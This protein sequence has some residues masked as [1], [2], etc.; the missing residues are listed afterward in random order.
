MNEMKKPKT[1]A[2]HGRLWSA[3][4]RD[5][6]EFQEV[7]FRPAYEAVFA[8]VG[9]KA[10]MA[11]LDVGCGAGLAANIAAS[12][13]VRVSGVD[14]AEGLLAIARQRTPK[15]D[16]RLGD[17]EELPFADRSFDIVT[18]FNSFQ[19]AGNPAAALAE[20]R[21]VTKPGGTIAILTWGK[22]EGMEMA[23][24]VTARRP[25]MP[26]PP[27]GTPGPFALS[28]ETT[29]RAFAASGGL[30]LEEIFD[31]PCAFAYPDLATALRGLKSSGD[32]LKTVEIAG[33]AVVDA[34]H[35]KALA[36]FR[37]K[38]GGYKAKGTF[39]CLLARP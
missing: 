34:A 6:A 9:L 31:V 38:D 39:R 22:P 4:A 2:I 13:G 23:S 16:F 1:A 5:W 30:K 10:G 19:F 25:L 17:L 33:E 24:L 3:G 28:D 12:R 20:A 26:P 32:A 7:N 36:P 18:G 11:Y 8:R 27:P 37:Q 29:L 21:R 15:G 35:E 14:A